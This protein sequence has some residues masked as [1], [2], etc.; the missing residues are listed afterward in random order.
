MDIKTVATKEWRVGQPWNPTS[1]KTG[2]IPVFPV[3]GPKECH[4][5]G[6]HSESRMESLEANQ[7]H[8]KYGL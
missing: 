6:F 2:Q 3:R 8:R 7:L 4:V 1:A 5:C